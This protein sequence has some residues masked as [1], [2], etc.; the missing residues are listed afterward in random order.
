MGCIGSKQQFFFFCEGTTEGER[1]EKK[2]H[3][4]KREGKGFTGYEAKRW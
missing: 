2:G 1:T 4:K 3:E